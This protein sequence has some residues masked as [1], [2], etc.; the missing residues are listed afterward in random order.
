MFLF[1][2]GNGACTFGL[3][4]YPTLWKQPVA[5]DTEYALKY[6]NICIIWSLYV[7]QVMF[8]TMF[9]LNFV[10]AVI[11]ENYG[12]K[13]A[14]R[15]MCVYQSR[16]LLNHECYQLMKHLKKLEPYRVIAFARAAIVQTAQSEDEQFNTKSDWMEGML[17][18]Q[19][20]D[21]G[22]KHENLQHSID[23]LKKTLEVQQKL[24][25]NNWETY[26]QKLDR[27]K[28]YVKDKY[29]VEESSRRTPTVSVSMAET[30]L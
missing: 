29:D 5:N 12:Q 24:V 20:N 6:V 9:G 15:K 11:E 8:Q 23:H 10:I 21:M 19:F 16:A 13:M 17:N 26:L 4:N 27:L 14:M 28:G 3:M 1:V 22:S 25:E 2:W 7:I 18:D 30:D